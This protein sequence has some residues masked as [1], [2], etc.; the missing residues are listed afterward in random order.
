MLVDI[1]K[2]QIT[3]TVPHD[4]VKTVLNAIWSIGAGVIGNYTNCSLSTKCIGTFKPNSQATPFIGNNNSLEHV[5]EEQIEVTCN[6][7]E[8]KKVVEKIREV[9]PYEEPAINIVPLIDINN[10]K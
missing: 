5:E 9:H 10:F 3:V 6:I 8:V 2:V 4:Y 7:N 1:Q